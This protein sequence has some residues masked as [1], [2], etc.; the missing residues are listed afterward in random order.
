[1]SCNPKY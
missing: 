1:V